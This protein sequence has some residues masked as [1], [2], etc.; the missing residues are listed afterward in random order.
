MG[1]RQGVVAWGVLLPSTGPALLSQLAQGV[2]LEM[3]KLNPG[4][5][6]LDSAIPGFMSW[7]SHLVTVWPWEGPSLS[8]WPIW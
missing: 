6:T 8:P 1:N 7:L 4:R 3:G 2:Y 5:E